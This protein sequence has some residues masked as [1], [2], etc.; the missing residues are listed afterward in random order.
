MEP[1]GI[2]FDY[3]LITSMKNSS[4]KI[5]LFNR[6]NYIIIVRKNFCKQH[7]LGSTLLTRYQS[8]WMPISIWS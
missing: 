6:L 4:N 7:K 2:N 8:F 5:F 3:F 1:I